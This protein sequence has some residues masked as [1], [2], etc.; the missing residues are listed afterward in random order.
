MKVLLHG[1]NW[2]LVDAKEKNI[3]VDERQGEET[4]ERDDLD[5]KKTRA[6]PSTSNLP[7]ILAFRISNSYS[8]WVEQV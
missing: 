1:T 4:G 8:T 3:K 7:L 2:S 6:Q 5:E